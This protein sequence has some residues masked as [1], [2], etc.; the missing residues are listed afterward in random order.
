MEDAQEMITPEAELEALAAELG[1]IPVKHKL[2]FLKG[3]IYYDSNEE[4]F[5][6]NP[7]VRPQETALI[8]L[9][10]GPDTEMMHSKFLGRL[11]TQ[12]N[13]MDSFPDKMEQLNSTNKTFHRFA[14]Q[15]VLTKCT[16]ANG[17]YVENDA[18]S[19]IVGCYLQLKSGL[20]IEIEWKIDVEWASY[21]VTGVDV[22]SHFLDIS[23]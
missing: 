3:G 22:K 1:C 15:I 17:L 10:A 13:A 18:E 19:C 16:T 14:Q 6:V 23:L 4:I 20:V 12:L 2:Y 8:M 5:C 21:S 11:V 7:N 9:K